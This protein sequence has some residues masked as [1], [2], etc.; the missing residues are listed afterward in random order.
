MFRVIV[1]NAKVLYS[2]RDLVGCGGVS[3]YATKKV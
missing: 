3:L 1:T 2:W